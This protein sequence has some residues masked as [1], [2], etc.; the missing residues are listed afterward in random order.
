MGLTERRTQPSVRLKLLLERFIWPLGMASSARTVGLGFAL[1]GFRR[2]RY[3][4]AVLFGCHDPHLDFRGKTSPVKDWRLFDI[5][6]AGPRR[7]ILC[8]VP[9]RLC[10]SFQAINCLVGLTARVVGSTWNPLA[11][12][13]DT[14]VA[15]ALWH[16]DLLQ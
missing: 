6:G 12:F 1:A 8:G 10:C 14:A 9:Q 7:G 2:R 4:H 5:A 15:V 3:D 13:G 16:Y 11:G